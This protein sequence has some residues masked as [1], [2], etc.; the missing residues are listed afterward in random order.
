MLMKSI[1]KIV[2][3]ALLLLAAVGCREIHT[4]TQESK[5]PIQ[6]GAYEVLVICNNIEWEGLLGQKLRDILEQPVEM[7]NQTE[8]MF[9]VLRITANDFRHLL[10]QH[11]NILKVVIDSKS[12]QAQITAE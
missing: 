3:F 8:P 5:K 4:L 9:N 10:V 12:E 2:T 1:T 7:L 11:R 6:G